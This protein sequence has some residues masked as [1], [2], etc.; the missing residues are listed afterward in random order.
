MVAGWGCGKSDG[1]V[2]EFGM[3]VLYLK[4]I[5]NKDLRAQG[6]LLNAMWQ[7]GWEGSVAEEGYMCVCVWVPLLLTWNYHNIVC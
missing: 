7:P 6:T 5:A 4:W 1:I 2:K 3:N